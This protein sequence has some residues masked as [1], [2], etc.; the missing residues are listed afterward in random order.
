MSQ[1][2]IKEIS[3]IGIIILIIFIGYFWEINILNSSSETLLEKVSEVK[4]NVENGYEKVNELY[5]EWKKINNVWSNIVI[6][7]ELE[8]IELAI[9]CTKTDIKRKNYDEALNELTKIE[10]LLNNILEKEKFSVKNIL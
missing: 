10:F 6:H 8:K 2:M 3:I 5:N 9:L 1:N 7:S 4:E